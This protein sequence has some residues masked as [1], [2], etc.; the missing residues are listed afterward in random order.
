MNDDFSELSWEERPQS[1]REIQQWLISS[2]TFECAT[3][4]AIPATSL[5]KPNVIKSRN[6][7]KPL[8]FLKPEPN[9][10][11]SAEFLT[12][13]TGI[14]LKKIFSNHKYKKSVFTRSCYSNR[15][16]SVQHSWCLHSKQESHFICFPT[17][18]FPFLPPT[19]LIS[20]WCSGFSLPLCAVVPSTALRTRGKNGE[21]QNLPFCPFE[22]FS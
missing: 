13:Q 1:D 6:R 2:V 14:L 19:E 22:K 16:C 18:S 15:T 11:C 3:K 7:L 9:L 10:Y 4:I 20:V 21:K 5:I 12:I 17:P 8:F